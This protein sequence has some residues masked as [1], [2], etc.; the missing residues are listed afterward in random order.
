MKNIK[1]AENINTGALC[2]FIKRCYADGTHI[3]SFQYARGED[4]L[5]KVGLEPY[6]FDEPMLVYSLSKS[7]TSICV[8]IAQSEGLLNIEERIVD[9]F[10]EKCPA[11]ISENLA[12]MRIKDCLCMTSGHSSCIF[13]HLQN[14]PDPIRYFLAQP[15]EN[16][17]GTNFVYCTASTYICGAAIS[18]RS[19]LDLLEYLYEKVFKKMEIEKPDWKSCADGSRHGGS[20]LFISSDTATKFGI[21]LLAGGV[22][23]G[24]RIVDEEWIK[25]ATSIHSVAPQNGTPDWIAGYGY[26]FWMN[27]KGGFRGDG[28]Y[29][30]LCL[31]FPERNI[32]FTLLCEAIYMQK[33]VDNIYQLLENIDKEDNSRLDELKELVQ[34][35]YKPEKC[36]NRFENKHYKVEKNIAGINEIQL[37][38]DTDGMTITLNCEYGTQK[39]EC[40]N[41]FYKR[42]SLLLRNFNPGIWT[43]FYYNEPNE[44]RFFAVYNDADENEITVTLRHINAPHTQTWHFPK[45]GNG[46]WTI[47]LH[48]GS[49]NSQLVKT[50]VYSL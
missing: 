22:Y 30:Q 37:E 44:H 14:D 8:G 21:M 11:V 43:N 25:I 49:L 38:K 36:S 7:F 20:G 6:S 35:L 27:A 5:A 24:I 41:G 45:N 47:S 13:E 12:K 29:G 15:V 10:P 1:L 32:V 4:V 46:D 23:N 3:H 34:N 48:C 9:I 18:K 17:P 2:D 33:E 50:P 26:Q 42:S 40:G 28:A 31:V 39:I 16:T 19:G